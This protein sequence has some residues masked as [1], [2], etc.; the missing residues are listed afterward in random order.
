MKEK[1]P[2]VS[3]VDYGRDGTT[4]KVSSCF[5]VICMYIFTYNVCILIRMCMH[6]YA[7]M[8]VWS[9]CPFFCMHCSCSVYT[10]I[11]AFMHDVQLCSI[12]Y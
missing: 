1:D 4:A 6:T 3:S 5:I 11:D 2:L 10:Y 9:L 7:C 8:Y 12:H